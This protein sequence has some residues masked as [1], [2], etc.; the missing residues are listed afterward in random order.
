MT[1]TG[2][3]DTGDI[4]LS[5]GEKWESGDIVGEGSNCEGINQSRFINLLNA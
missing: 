4:G 3:R 5:R 1:R 2:T